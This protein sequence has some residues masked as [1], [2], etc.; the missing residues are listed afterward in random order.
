MTITA[1]VLSIKR[2]DFTTEKNETVKGYQVWMSAPADSP[3]WNGPEILKCF[4]KDEHSHAADAAALIPG[5]NVLFEFNRYNK[6]VIV[7]FAPVTV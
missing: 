2:L 5:D 1:K 7:D 6:P 4:V 3:S